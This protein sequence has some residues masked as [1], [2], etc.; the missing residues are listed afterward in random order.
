MNL[1]NVSIIHRSIAIFHFTSFHSASDAPSH[2]SVCVRPARGLW[3]WTAT[4]PH[5]LEG[6]SHHHWSVEEEHQTASAA[7]KQPPADLL[8][9]SSESEVRLTPFL[10]LSPFLFPSLPAD[11][12]AER[13]TRPPA[14]ASVRGPRPSSGRR[15]RRRSR[16]SLPV[17]VSRDCPS[18]RERLHP[19]TRTLP[20]CR[21]SPSLLPS[22][23]GLGQFIWSSGREDG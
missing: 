11:S 6:L 12:A 5:N 15:G 10:S 8:S 22:S 14:R 23:G 4:P 3:T 19:R 7:S 21:A 20:S 16:C 9:I 2:G 18:E 1:R 17:K 13:S